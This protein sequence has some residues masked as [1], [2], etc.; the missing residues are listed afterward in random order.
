MKYTEI[1]EESIDKLMNIFYPLVRV[2]PQLGPIFNGAIGTDDEHWTH[3]IEKIAGFWKTMLLGKK[4]YSGV[5]IFAHKALMPFEIELFDVWLGL[6]RDC[7]DK[8]YEAGPANEY[9]S[10]ANNIANNFKMVLFNK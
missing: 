10:F 7:L 6:F 2:E 5:P 8:V 1:S 4:L 3:H 9:F